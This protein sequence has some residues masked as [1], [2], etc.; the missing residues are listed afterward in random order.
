MSLAVN[1]RWTAFAIHL[2]LSILLLLVLLSIIFFIWFPYDLIFAGGIE[3]LKILMGVDLILGPLLT[4]IVFNNAKKSLKF[5]LTMIG[6][7]Q[8]G[9]LAAGLWLIYNERPVAQIL[10]DDGM[11]LHS[12][13]E[14][15]TYNIQKPSLAGP[16]PSHVLLDLPE[17][18][19]E[20][21]NLRIT[22]SLISTV[23]LTTRTDLWLAAQD[24]DEAT[25][26]KRLQL[27]KEVI[28]GK[29]LSVIDELPKLNCTWVPLHSIHNDGYA[30]TNY[31]N[32][33]IQLSKKERW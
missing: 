3:G 30:C 32:G 9:C 26:A 22:A 28:E 21:V 11:Y 14:F 16:N 19:Q 5:D 20:M 2:G 29:Q 4:L 7:L 31:E 1:S 23:P 17:N 33:I 27:I 15:D 13:G 12:A 6:I 18:R 8:V 25:Y 10:A 24:I